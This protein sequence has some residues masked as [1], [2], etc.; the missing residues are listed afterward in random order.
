MIKNN[1]GG[2][3]SDCGGLGL[4][5]AP[6][7][8]RQICRITKSAAIL[9]GIVFVL[10]AVMLVVSIV[11]RKLFGWQVSGDVELVQMVGAAA[12]SL[13]FPWCHLMKGNVFVDM[14]TARCPV[15]FND[16]L[17]R[18]GSVLV[19]LAG[20]G[21]AWRTWA[22][23]MESKEYQVISPMLGWQEWVWPA[24]MVPG[25]VL[26]AVVGFYCALF[27]SAFG[28]DEMEAL[29]QPGEGA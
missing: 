11:S 17:D 24:L 27:P 16:A 28:P 14:F 4:A 6:P 13:F 3:V 25:F 23:A 12:A 29:L 5:D 10:L 9:G 2:A 19:G 26:M 7:G 22:L 18:L 1:N 8:Y 15:W 21:M 20:A